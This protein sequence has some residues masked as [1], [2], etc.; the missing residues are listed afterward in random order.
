MVLFVM[1]FPVLA[2]EIVAPPDVV[3][4]SAGRAII[5]SD[6]A[7]RERAYR[8]DEAAYG[9]SL[10]RQRR[11]YEGEPVRQSIGHGTYEITRNLISQADYRKFVKATGHR[12][13]GVTVDV[14][15][16]Y[17]LI[18]PFKR[19]EPYRWLNNQPVAGRES[20]PVVLVAHRDARAYAVWL[21]A[22]TGQHWRLPTEQEWEIAARGRDGRAFPWGDEF[23]PDRLN[24]HDQ[25][26]F[27]T[28][29]VGQ[30]REGASPFGMMDAAGQVFE[31]TATQ[32]GENRF[33]VKGGS[34][35]DSGCGICRPAARHS[36]PAELKHILI[37]FRLVRQLESK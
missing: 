19:T 3:R 1:P 30:F 29:P 15:V 23:A 5:G 10:T 28:V 11:W 7:E 37:G 8:L 16:G 36:R 20:H 27:A 12:A 33:I 18:H 21:S 2:G 25:G 6:R 32:A 4:V 17:G 14:W 13:P 24:S 26:P 9:H 34:W 31:W 35:D 22:A